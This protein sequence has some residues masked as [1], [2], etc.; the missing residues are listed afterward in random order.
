M[1]IVDM[2][3]VKGNGELSETSQHHPTE[4]CS[5]RDL[6]QVEGVLFTRNR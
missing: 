2:V 3:V 6:C 4:F 5:F 1:K